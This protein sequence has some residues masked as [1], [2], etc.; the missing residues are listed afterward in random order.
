MG[1]FRNHRA[2]TDKRARPQ[3]TSGP[4]KGQ[5]AKGI[6]RGIALKGGVEKMG[7]EGED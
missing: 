3:K 2:T 1:C 4:G 5:S 6:R 7:S